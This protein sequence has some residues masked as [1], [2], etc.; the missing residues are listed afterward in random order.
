MRKC[1]SR[2][3]TQSPMSLSIIVTRQASAK[4]MGRFLYFS[5]NA[6]TFSR[7]SSKL[8]GTWINPAANHAAIC[9][10]ARGCFWR[11]KQASVKTDSHVKKGGWSFLAR[12]T[13]I[14]CHW[15][16]ASNQATNGPVSSKRRLLNVRT[17]SYV[18]DLWRGHRYHFSHCRSRS[19]SNRTLKAPPPRQP[20]HPSHV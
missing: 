1:S 5:I 18:W 17:L 8:N 20:L 12:A 14:L 13:A 6:K 7:D 16:S 4:D 3:K 19:S 15:S 2:V 9:S 11:R 10:T